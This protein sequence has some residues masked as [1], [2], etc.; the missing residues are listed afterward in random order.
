MPF[1]RPLTWL[2]A[3]ILDLMLWIIG[4]YR[5]HILTSCGDIVRGPSDV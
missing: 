2:E 1:D 4:D 5:K 3:D